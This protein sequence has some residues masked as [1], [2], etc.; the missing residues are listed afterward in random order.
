MAATLGMITG[1]HVYS[2]RLLAWGLVFVAAG[3]SWAALLKPQSSIGK[4]GALILVASS[5]LLVPLLSAV[6]VA[7]LLGVPFLDAWFESVS[8]FTTTGLSVFNGKVDPVFGR[9]VPSV[10]ELPWSMLWWRAVT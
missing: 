4:E 6:P 10:E 5:W 7:H 1:D 2:L 3:L 8:G 9:Y